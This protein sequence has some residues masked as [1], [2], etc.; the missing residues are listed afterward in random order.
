MHIILH[1]ILVWFFLEVLPLFSP[2]KPRCNIPF[3]GNLTLR[4]I[5]SDD[6][7]KFTFYLYLL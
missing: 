5:G 3:I 6:F 4:I 2:N 1:E 7:F